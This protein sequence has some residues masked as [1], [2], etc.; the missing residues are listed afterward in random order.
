EV[1][2]GAFATTSAARSAARAYALAP[3]DA[4]GERAATDAARQAL[5][6]QGLD[7]V[8]VRVEVSCT[9][10]DDCH[11]GESIITVRVDTTVDLP[12]LPEMLGGGTP[13]FALDATHTVPIG[14]YQEITG[15]AARD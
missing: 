13:S 14:R 1:Q 6:D 4:A 2:R 15:A 11:S 5:D 10:H 8:P 7:G 3:S 9:P 12:L